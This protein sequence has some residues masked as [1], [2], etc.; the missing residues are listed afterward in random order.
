MT[1]AP[2]PIDVLHD[3]VDLLA[4]GI[5]TLA[6]AIAHRGDADLSATVR[7]LARQVESIVARVERLAEGES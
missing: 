5:H 2:S 3:E 7:L 6:D 4:G 1:Q